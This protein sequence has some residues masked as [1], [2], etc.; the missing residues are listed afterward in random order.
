M[1]FRSAHGGSSG[2]AALDVPATDVVVE[3]DRETKVDLDASTIVPAT[4]HGRALLDGA[5]PP[6]ARI[7]LQ[8]A[9]G[10]RCGQFVVAADGTFTAPDLLPGTYRIH[11]VVGDFQAGPGDTI[12]SAEPFELTAGQQLTRDFVFV[13]RRLVI[14]LLQADGET[15]RER[16]VHAQRRP[17]DA[18]RPRPRTRTAGLSSTRRRRVPSTCSRATPGRRSVPCSCRRGSRA[19]R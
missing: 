5:P 13:H 18:A 17:G 4:L 16:H 8:T 19:V 6:A 7:F 11:L 12:P 14:T 9:R 1:P 15:R 10:S 2:A 3:A